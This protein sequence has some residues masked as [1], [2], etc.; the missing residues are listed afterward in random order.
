VDALNSTDAWATGQTE[1]VAPVGQS[2]TVAL[3]WD[4]T[5]WTRIPTPDV[6]AQNGDFGHLL[7]VSA[8]APDDVW[9]VGIAANQPGTFGTGD[10][11]L[12]EHWDGNSWS[13]RGGFPADSRLVSVTAV[14][15]D[16]VWAVGSTGYS[17]SFKPLV[18]HWDGSVWNEVSTGGSGEAWLSGISATPSGDLWAVGYQ[19]QRTLTILCA[20]D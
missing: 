13:V 2:N 16:D 18:L 7:G 5:A 1:N 14:S 19:D 15:A 8:L 6:A 20:R 3:H 9:A 11:A 17:G 12:I 4:G 10:Q